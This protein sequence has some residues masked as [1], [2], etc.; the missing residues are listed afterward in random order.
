M[1]NHHAPR[2]NCFRGYTNLIQFDSICST[3]PIS[4]E[5][6]WHGYSMSIDFLNIA[7]RKELN[8]PGTVHTG[9]HTVHTLLVTH[10][11][12]L[13]GYHYG[14]GWATSNAYW[15]TVVCLKG[16]SGVDISFMG[17]PYIHFTVHI[18]CMSARKGTLRMCMY[19]DICTY[20]KCI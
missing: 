7:T 4:S 8:P 14:K 18:W 19:I 11:L 9:S 5:T 1:K 2:L 6:T 3:N 15:H 17:H 13:P 20:C 10:H 12:D 16:G